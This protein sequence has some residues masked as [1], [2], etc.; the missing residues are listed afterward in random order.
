MVRTDYYCLDGFKTV[1]HGG[2]YASSHV[3]TYTLHVLIIAS[4]VRRRLPKRG[5]AW[6]QG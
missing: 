3:R 5:E 2:G 6:V 1:K 4:P